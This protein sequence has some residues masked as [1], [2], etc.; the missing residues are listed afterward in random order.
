MNL[1][2]TLPNYL[3]SS[4][5]A[6]CRD[7]PGKSFELTPGTPVTKQAHQWA[8]VYPVSS[9][10]AGKSKSELEIQIDS[11]VTNIFKNGE[12]VTFTITKFMS[13]NTSGIIYSP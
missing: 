5:N 8:C 13:E 6:R 12:S 10:L 1:V 3:S 11:E 7:P 2:L 4:K 9:S